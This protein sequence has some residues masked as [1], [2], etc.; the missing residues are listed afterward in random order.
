MLSTCKNAK[1]LSCI[2]IAHIH[3]QKTYFSLHCLALYQSWKNLW[4]NPISTCWSWPCPKQALCLQ[5]K[6]FENTAGKGKIAR[7]EQF[8]LLPQCFLPVWRTFFHFH[9]IW[10][11]C[12]Q[13]L[14]VWKSL[15]LVVWERV[16]TCL[17]Y[18]RTKWRADGHMTQGRFKID[19]RQQI[20]YK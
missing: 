17:N 20:Q 4:S 7:N 15:K 11:C 5:Y 10:N 14:S 19:S 8:L 12:L 2:K 1:F 9:K 3:W 18:T 6:S 16:E 13:N